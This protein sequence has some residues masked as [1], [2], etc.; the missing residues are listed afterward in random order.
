MGRRP[1]L[2]F[3]QKVIP[4]SPR[5]PPF[6]LGAAGIIVV[7]VDIF[8]IF[9]ILA[10]FV[11]LDVPIVAVVVAGWESGGIRTHAGRLI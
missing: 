6:P 7:A 8:I 1:S 4:S 9:V 2:L 5:L 3:N 10:A 11:A